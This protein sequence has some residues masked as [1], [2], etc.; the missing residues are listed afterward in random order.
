MKDNSREQSPF[1]QFYTQKLA[2]Y[3]YL[4]RSHGIKSNGFDF[5]FPKVSSLNTENIAFLRGVHFSYEI[6]SPSAKY[7]NRRYMLTV[8]DDISAKDFLDLPITHFKGFM[9]EQIMRITLM[10]FLRRKQEELGV[11]KFDFI[12]KNLDNKNQLN[13]ENYYSE[14][15]SR[16]SISIRS[17]EDDSV[18]REFDGILKYDNNTFNPGIIACEAKTGC[19][20]YIANCETQYGRR[21]VKKMVINP[22]QEMFE[23]QNIDFLLMAQKDEIFSNIND[24]RLKSKISN[25]VDYFSDN[26]IGVLL[27]EYN[28]SKSIFNSIATQMSNFRKSIFENKDQIENLQHDQINQNWFEDDKYMYILKG[29]RFERILEKTN[30]TYKVVYGIE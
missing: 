15:N 23:G 4:P 3:K 30:G 20:E 29:K 2:Q 10:E 7:G 9:G 11:N 21:K 17:R 5:Y 16:Y 27:F 12:K 28:E 24:R 1:T 25:M 18:V 26:N 13:S 8:S 6:E 22:L 19:L 14:H